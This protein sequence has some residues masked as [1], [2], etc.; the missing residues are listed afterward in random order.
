MNNTILQVPMNRKLRD[1]A[2]IAVRSQGFSSLQEAVRVFLSG[3]ATGIHRVTF[4]PPKI[5]LSTRA[6]HR[7]NKMIDEIKSKKVKTKEFTNVKDM[8]RYLN[9]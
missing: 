1:D 8:M 3:M 5:Q 2:T 4:E 9:T 6:I 7:Y